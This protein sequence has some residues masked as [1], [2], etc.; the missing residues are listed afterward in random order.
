[1]THLLL[2][3]SLDTTQGRRQRLPSTQ[4]LG[5]LGRGKALSMGSETTEEQR[6]ELGWL[7]P[8]KRAGTASAEPFTVALSVPTSFGPWCV[9]GR[10]GYAAT[11]AQVWW[12]VC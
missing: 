11:A 3:G 2:F 9:L 7:L 5:G 6:N 1:M 10:H 8:L 4:G 12:P